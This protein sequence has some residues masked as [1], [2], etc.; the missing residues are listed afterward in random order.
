M[1][2]HMVRV[3]DPR[4][5]T[6]TGA[7]DC[8]TKVQPVQTRPNHNDGKHEVRRQ[9]YISTRSLCFEVKK[10]IV[11]EGDDCC[12][13]SIILQLHLARRVN[14][15]IVGVVLLRFFEERFQG[16]SDVLTIKGETWSI[17]PSWAKL[18]L[19]MGP[20][21]DGDNRT[22]GRYRRADCLLL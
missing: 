17:P 11:E 5:C 15:A 8:S 9:A 14:F 7:D 16:T 4:C 18:S 6:T 20:I 12:D 19:P 21:T 3:H 1:Y 13:S 10:G 2:L 22:I